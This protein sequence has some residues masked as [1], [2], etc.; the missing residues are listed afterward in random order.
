MLAPIRRIVCAS[1]PLA[2]SSVWVASGGTV[3]VGGTERRKMSLRIAVCAS[4]TCY[5]DGSRGISN[6]LA[7]SENSDNTPKGYPGGQSNFDVSTGKELQS[8]AV[9][10]ALSL[11]STAS[12]AFA[13]T[14][15]AAGQASLLQKGAQAFDSAIASAGTF[16]SESPVN[17]TLVQQG[18]IFLALPGLSRSHMLEMFPYKS[19]L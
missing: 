16:N 11:F 10:N 3:R 17:L 19:G 12:T 6:H 18:I 14:S 7:T 4:M 2:A 1:G 13:W 8:N 15:I 5:P 9:S